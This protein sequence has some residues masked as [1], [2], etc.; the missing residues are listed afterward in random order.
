MNRKITEFIYKV[1]KFNILEFLLTNKVKRLEKD[2]DLDV[3]LI[4][5][6]LDLIKKANLSIDT[7]KAIIDGLYI[8][9]NHTENKIE[10][11]DKIIEV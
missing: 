9:I 6:H 3:S 4:D 1:R 10:D 7:S 8:Q 2:R 5:Y 11:I